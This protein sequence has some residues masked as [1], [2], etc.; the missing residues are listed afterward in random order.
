MP[1]NISKSGFRNWKVSR[2]PDLSGKTFMITGG[3][4]GIG[5]EAAKYLGEA[6]G[7]L[8]IAARNPDKAARSIEALKP[9]VKGSLDHIT[10]DL[11]DLSAVRA[12]AEETRSKV[13]KLDALVNNAGIMQTPAQKTKDGFE[14][15]I[16]TNH[17]GH[18]LL[19]GLLF[20]LVENASGRI[21]TVSSIAHK[22]GRMFLDDLM[23]TENY[24][25]TYAYGQSKLANMLYAIELDRKLKASGSPVTSYACHPG[26][27]DTSL[28]STG[29]TGFWKGMYKITNALMAQ[30]AAKGAIP[31][32]LCAAGTEAIPG[33][34]YGPTGMGESR[35]PVSDALVSEKALNEA[36]A[37]T[38][39]QQSETLVN[40]SWDQVLS[41]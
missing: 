17:L 29:P 24:S 2:L 26:Y 6:G 40:F 41:A 7:D 13:A 8:I 22:Y 30:P 35:G 16:G 28:Q 37:K 18:F 34:Y 3:N 19:N 5:F 11:A 10:L 39:W 36:D 25:P 32:V 31:T 14:M 20:D 9:V 27:S 33:A 4:S 12:A 1:K 15:Q 38:L 21:V 23:M